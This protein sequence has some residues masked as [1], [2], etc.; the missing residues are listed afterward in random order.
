MGESFGLIDG[1]GISFSIEH[2]NDSAAASSNFIKF[3]SY[4]SFEVGNVN[5]LIF[6]VHS[7]FLFFVET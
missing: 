4:F 3:D 2:D 5:N 6:D 7:H 1:N